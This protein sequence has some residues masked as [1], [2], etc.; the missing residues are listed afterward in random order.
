MELIFCFIIIII[1]ICFLLLNR[2]S[3]ENY[4]N[5]DII[6]FIHIPKNAGTSIKDLCNDKLIYNGHQ[7]D[8]FNQELSN[9]LVILRNPAE[10][11]ASSVNYG[12]ETFSFKEN[13][14][15][16]KANKVLIQKSGYFSRSA[17]A[18]AK[19]LKLIF[20]C[21]DLAM[22]SAINGK[23][24]VVGMDEDNNNHLSCIDFKRI[25]GGKPFDINQSWY[26]NMID[27]INIV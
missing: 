21:A 7:T 15:R 12:L 19:D 14:K 2:N 25:K 1:I 6:N 17:K 23:S 9:Q 26:I 5:D 10:R 3:I 20:D 24:G 22:I 16:L 18:N 13:V 8:V 11:F 4:T 27:E